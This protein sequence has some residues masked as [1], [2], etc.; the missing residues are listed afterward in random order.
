LSEHRSTMDPASCLFRLRQGNRSIEDYIMDFCG[1]DV[2]LKDIFRHGLN[3]PIH[4]YL[5]GVKIHWSLEQYID[6]ALLLSGSSFTVGIADEESC[7]P[8]V[9][10]TPE[11]FHSKMAAIPWSVHKMAAISRPAHV[12]PA[13]PGPAHEM[14]APSR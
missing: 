5:P 11:H 8:T 3:E 1:L 9:P 12:M 2:A 14:A 6:H 7:N 13:A 10:I 4:S